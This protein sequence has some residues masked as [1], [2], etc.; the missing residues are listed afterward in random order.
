[1]AL[2]ISRNT[3]YSPGSPIY[4]ADLNALQDCVIARKGGK[5]AHSIS[6]ANANGGGGSYQDSVALTGSAIDVVGIGPAI[7]A[8]VY[9]ATVLVN[10]TGTAVYTLQLWSTIVLGTG[11]GAAGPIAVSAPSSG[12]GRQRLTI[13]DSAVN[14]GLGILADDNRVFSLILVFQSGVPAPNTQVFRYTWTDAML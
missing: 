8:T 11:A 6:R 12:T 2:P 3:T 5:I 10:P 14:G 1:M 13:P 9:G 7:G 4:S